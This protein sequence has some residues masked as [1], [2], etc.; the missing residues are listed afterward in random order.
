MKRSASPAET[1]LSALPGCVLRT[2]WPRRRA[3]TLGCAKTAF[4]SAQ[5][6]PDI[7]SPPQ[8][9]DDFPY[10]RARAHRGQ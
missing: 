10:L 2:G 5:S 1:G 3:G 9:L 8:K 4:G 7:A 6:S